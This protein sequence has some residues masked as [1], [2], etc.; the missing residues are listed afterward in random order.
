MPTADS[1]QLYHPMTLQSMPSAPGGYHHHGSDHTS[2]RSMLGMPIS[3]SSH[4]MSGMDYNQRHM[5]PYPSPHSAGP[6]PPSHYM[7]SDMP[8]S[9]PPSIPSNPFTSPHPPAQQNMYPS[10]NPSPRLSSHS[11]QP[12]QSPQ[13]YFDGAHSHSGSAPGSGYATPQ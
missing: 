5:G 9:A 12:E 7:S 3:R 13:H 6:A 2:S 1:L 8:L 4:A 11:A 10:F